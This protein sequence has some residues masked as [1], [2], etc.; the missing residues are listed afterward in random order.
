MRKSRADHGHFLQVA[1]WRPFSFEA[2]HL[3]LVLDRYFL[4]QALSSAT[5]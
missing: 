3:P 1:K 2:R 5:P 4:Y